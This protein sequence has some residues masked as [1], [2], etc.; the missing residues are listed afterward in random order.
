MG[1]VSICARVYTERTSKTE[2]VR[3][4]APIDKNNLFDLLGKCFFEKN[5]PPT[6]I[7]MRI[8]AKS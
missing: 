7:Q 4:N 5:R 1:P 3:I 8:A 6:I 2:A